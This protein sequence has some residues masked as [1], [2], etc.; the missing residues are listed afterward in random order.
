MYWADVCHPSL[1]VVQQLEHAFGF[2]PL[3]TEDVFITS[4]REKVEE[5][6]KYLYIVFAERQF[7]PNSNNV[8]LANVNIL[9]FR[10][11]ILS[12]HIHPVRCF[13]PVGHIY[14][15]V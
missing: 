10:N 8:R 2:H 14:I 4:T 9:L 3:T 5:F 12:I 11:F 15:L 13:S 6:P 7:E 1:E